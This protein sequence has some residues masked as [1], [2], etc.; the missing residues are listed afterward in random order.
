MRGLPA[1]INRRSYL[2]VI[3]ETEAHIRRGESELTSFSVA[4]FATA[5][6]VGGRLAIRPS[7]ECDTGC[8]AARFDFHSVESGAVVASATMPAALSR[9]HSDGQ[10]LYVHTYPDG[11]FPSDD[12]VA[13]DPFAHQLIRVSPETGELFRLPPPDD[14]ALDDFAV[15]PGAVFV[16]DDASR[17]FKLAPDGTVVGSATLGEPS[18]GLPLVAASG[19]GVFAQTNRGR[20]V[21]FDEDLASSRSAAGCEEHL[22]RFGFDDV[23]VGERYSPGVDLSGYVSLEAWRPTPAGSDT[24]TFELVAS[25]PLPGGG[26][27]GVPLESSGGPA[28][29]FWNGGLIELRVNEP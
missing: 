5:L 2:P 26:A 18:G 11:V 13:P 14:V 29:G 23:L 15:I 9:T 12:F 24:F 10:A 20:W 3:D 1:E 6:W 17:L 25:F 27:N 16:L 28:V 19:L 22:V 7:Q 8:G 21:W 4:P